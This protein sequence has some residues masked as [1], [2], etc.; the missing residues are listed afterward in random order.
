[1]AVKEF[2]GLVDVEMTWTAIIQGAMVK[3]VFP[4]LK[5]GFPSF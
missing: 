1:V 3:G 4:V 5:L 2:L